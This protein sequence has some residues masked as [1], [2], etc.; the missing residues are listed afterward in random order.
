[1]K[2][3]I[4][5]NLLTLSNYNIMLVLT[6]KQFLNKFHIDFQPPIL[7]F[8]IKVLL[9]DLAQLSIAKLCATYSTTFFS[10]VLRFVTSLSTISRLTRYFQMFF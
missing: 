5:V 9:Y 4:S 8:D 10:K 2:Y 7:R 6:Q 1:M 3:A